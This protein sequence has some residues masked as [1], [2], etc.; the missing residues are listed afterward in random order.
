[1]HGCFSFC[2]CICNYNNFLMNRTLILLEDKLLPVFKHVFFW[3]EENV[4]LII[5]TTKLQDTP[6]THTPSSVGIK[7]KEKIIISNVQFDR[8]VFIYIATLDI[9]VKITEEYPHVFFYIQVPNFQQT[10]HRAV[11]VDRCQSPY[12]YSLPF[13]S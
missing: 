7:I 1:M 8:C 9:I 12:H 10:E 13:Q 2:F 4:I 3:S 6:H 5:V 11:Q